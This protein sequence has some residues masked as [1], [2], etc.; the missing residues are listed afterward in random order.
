MKKM[1]KVIAILLA[2]LL[3]ASGC[4]LLGGGD[5]SPTEAPTE[6]PTPTPLLSGSAWQTVSRTDGC[7]HPV[8]KSVGVLS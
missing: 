3:T 4:A 2:V 7:K 1:L 6:E 5:A 8:T